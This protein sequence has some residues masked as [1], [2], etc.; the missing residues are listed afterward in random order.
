MVLN[1]ANSKSQIDKPQCGCPKR[2]ELLDVEINTGM[3]SINTERASLISMLNQ[4]I[5]QSINQSKTLFNE[6]D[7]KQCIALMNLWPSTCGCVCFLSKWNT[8]LYRCDGKRSRY[9]RGP[10][11]LTV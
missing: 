11:G 4:S 2:A 9:P 8:Y 1:M 3:Q 6:C 5:N 10:L 7:T